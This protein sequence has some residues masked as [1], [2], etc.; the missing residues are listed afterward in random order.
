MGLTRHGYQQTYW[1]AISVVLGAIKVFILR[2][3]QYDQEDTWWFSQHGTGN[4][5]TF[6]QILPLALLAAPLLSVGDY[7]MSHTAE[8]H[9]GPPRVCTG[10][11]T[12]VS[13]AMAHT[14]GLPLCSYMPNDIECIPRTQTADTDDVAEPETSG[15][16]YLGNIPS[17]PHALSFMV[18][19]YVSVPVFILHYVT[20]D[21]RSTNTVANLARAFSLDAVLILP[22]IQMAWIVAGLWAAK[23]KARAI[24][25]DLSG[26]A[27]YTSFI[28]ALWFINSGPSSLDDAKFFAS[29]LPGIYTYL[30]AW[31]TL[32]LRLRG[33]GGRHFDAPRNKPRQYALQL[34][35]SAVFFAASVAVFKFWLPETI[36][37]NYRTRDI[38]ALSWG[39]PVA[40]PCISMLARGAIVAAENRFGH[41]NTSLRILR[42]LLNATFHLG[43]PLS[44]FLVYSKDLDVIFNSGLL[45]IFPSGLPLVLAPFTVLSFISTIWCSWRMLRLSCR[46]RGTQGGGQSPSDQIDEIS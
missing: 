45:I 39:V 25:T 10:K 11:Y 41:G 3:S 22:A 36:W 15:A 37:I 35:A 4:T 13:I 12:V 20:P 6:G 27:I 34:G 5:W 16:V 40:V 30:V 46:P 2:D 38:I 19:N 28:L 24:I 29:I 33:P 8:S 43:V 26:T 21:S 7:F 17:Y 23:V 31:W 18:W 1:L 9:D 44:C 14:H 42:W 32:D